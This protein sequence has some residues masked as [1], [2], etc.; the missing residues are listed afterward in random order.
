M[1]SAGLELAD[2][3]GLWS[4]QT[5]IRN[6]ERNIGRFRESDTTP[7]RLAPSC[8]GPICSFAVAILTSALDAYGKA[9]VE[10]DGH[11]AGVVK[12][13]CAAVRPQ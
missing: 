3:T 4:G 10:F 5:Q 11:A 2:P 13:C 8:G 7:V 6:Q 9:Y 1:G 12:R